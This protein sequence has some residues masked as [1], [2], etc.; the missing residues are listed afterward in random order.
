MQKD[1]ESFFVYFFFTLS[2]AHPCFHIDFEDIFLPFSSFI[3]FYVYV[4]IREKRCLYL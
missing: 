1:V 2:L 4:F 3:S